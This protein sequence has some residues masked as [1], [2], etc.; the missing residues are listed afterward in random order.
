MT[1]YSTRSPT[2]S[3]KAKYIKRLSMKG[4]K[5]PKVWQLGRRHHPQTMTLLEARLLNI[6]DSN[7][8]SLV[9]IIVQAKRPISNS[10]P[11]AALLSTLKVLI[12]SSSSRGTRQGRQGNHRLK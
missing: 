10:L 11:M 1:T 4:P 12:T 2:L 9:A 7:L 5:K 8:N 3:A 6:A